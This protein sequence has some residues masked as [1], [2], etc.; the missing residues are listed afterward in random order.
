VFRFKHLSVVHCSSFNW[1]NSRK[2]RQNFVH[3]DLLFLYIAAYIDHLPHT[4]AT[5]LCGGGKNRI[6]WVQANYLLLMNAVIF[7]QSAMCAWQLECYAKQMNNTPNNLS[8]YPDMRRFGNWSIPGVMWP[9][10]GWQVT[11]GRLAENTFLFTIE[12][13]WARKDAE[14][15][16]RWFSNGVKSI[17][18]HYNTLECKKIHQW[19]NH[20]TVEI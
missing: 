2:K 17:Q 6:W 9:K 5:G 7:F 19:K 12:Y 4:F 14:G 10:F 18:V 1:H 8:L 16:D 20:E 13:F 11:S 3:W 15:L